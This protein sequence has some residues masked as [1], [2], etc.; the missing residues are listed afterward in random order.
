MSLVFVSIL[1]ADISFG[2]ELEP[3]SYDEQL[4][5]EMTK[6]ELKVEQMEK[7]MKDTQTDI[8]RVLEKVSS[9]LEN[10]TKEFNRVKGTLIRAVCLFILE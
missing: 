1:L 7:R 10:K 3:V 6:M 4:L 5:G 8:K 9:V 2:K